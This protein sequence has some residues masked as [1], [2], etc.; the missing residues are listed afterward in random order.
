MP[1]KTVEIIVKTEQKLYGLWKKSNDRSISEDIRVLSEAYHKA[2]GQPDTVLPFFVLSSNYKAQTQDFELFIGSVSEREGLEEHTIPAGAYAK[3]TVRPRLK[4]LWGRAIGVA[5][6]YFYTRWLPE[7][8][9]EALNMEYE[10]HTEKSV[11]RH[12]EVDLIF[13]VK[14][15]DRL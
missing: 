15:K 8:A 1:D 4:C 6:R 7:S 13:A 10:Y 11:G 3:M 5:K 12:P 9:Y 2:V 14:K